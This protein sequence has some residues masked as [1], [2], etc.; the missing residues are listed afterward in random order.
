[1]RKFINPAYARRHLAHETERDGGGEWRENEAEHLIFGRCSELRV[2]SGG[3][4][5][6]K[7]EGGRR[8]VNLSEHLSKEQSRDVPGV[9]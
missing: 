2:G 3:S 1:M 6:V 8:L 7:V 9:C 5:V 4:S